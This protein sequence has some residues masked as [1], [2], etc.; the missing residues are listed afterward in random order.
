LKTLHCRSVAA[1][2]DVL[3]STGFESETVPMSSGTPFANVLIIA[4]PR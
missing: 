3:S 1:W 4:K 2:R